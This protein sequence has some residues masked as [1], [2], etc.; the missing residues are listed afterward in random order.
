MTAESR[1]IAPGRVRPQTG[2]KSMMSRQSGSTRYTGGS[3]ASS[4]QNDENESIMSSII[5]NM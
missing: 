2:R 5:G 1:K 4:R 3:R